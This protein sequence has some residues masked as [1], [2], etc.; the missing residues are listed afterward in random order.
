MLQI[1]EM[2]KECLRQKDVEFKI[3]P[4]PPGSS[5]E[6]AAHEMVKRCSCVDA[7]SFSPLRR[8]LSKKRSTQTAGTVVI[9]QADEFGTPE[10]IQVSL[11]IIW[12]CM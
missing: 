4:A 9:T 7:S 2:T 12:G 11:V 6:E 1:K 8:L 5:R 10:Q 3:E